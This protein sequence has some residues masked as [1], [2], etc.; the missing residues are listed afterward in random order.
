MTTELR[1]CPFCGG[2]AKQGEFQGRWVV[3]CINGLTDD[4]SKCPIAAETH[5]YP[6]EAEAARAWN[7]RADDA[8]H[9]EAVAAAKAEG[10]AAE[11]ARIVAALSEEAEAATTGTVALA[12]Q[13]AIAIVQGGEP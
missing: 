6:T 11:R 13:D 5:S 8:R 3:Y 10:A 4:P 12:F 7:T 2:A 9:A 1:E